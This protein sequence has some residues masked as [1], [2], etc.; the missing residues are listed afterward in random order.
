MTLGSRRDVAW[1]PGDF[2]D[3]YEATWK[4]FI[5]PLIGMKYLQRRARA[6]RPILAYQ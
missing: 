4:D 2:K 6:Y 3:G 1:V 5:V